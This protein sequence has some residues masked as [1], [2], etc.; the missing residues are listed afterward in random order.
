MFNGFHYSSTDK[1]ISV[2][3]A[4]KVLI[5]NYSIT[6]VNGQTIIYIS[7]PLDTGCTVNGNYSL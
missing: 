5:Y 6:K 3:Y 7:W 4:D 1:E 2:T